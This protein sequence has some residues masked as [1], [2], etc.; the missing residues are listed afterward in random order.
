MTVY[1]HDGEFPPDDR[2]EWSDL[3]PLLGPTA[4]AIARYDG[5]LGLI[6][7]PLSLLTP[8]KVQEA[9]FSSRIEGTQTTVIEVLRSESGGGRVPMSAERQL[10]IQEVLNYINAMNKAE[11]LLEKYPLSQRVI[12]ES[13]IILMQGLRGHGKSPGQ[14][15]RIQNW[16]GPSNCKI[17]EAKFVPVDA[18]KLDD[19]MSKWEKYIHQDHPDQLVQLAI[20]H[21]EFES[22]H[23]FLDGNGRLGRMLIPLFLWQQN[24]LQ[25]PIFNISSYF[26]ADRDSYY[27]GLLS[28]SKDKNWTRWIKYFL[29]ALGKQAE[30]NYQKSYKILELYE[31][32][33]EEV[34]KN[35]RSQYAIL[36]LD[37]I[38]NNPVFR[39]SRFKNNQG[40]P[41]ASANRVL[42]AFKNLDILTEYEKKRGNISAVY[43]FPKLIEI[44][45]S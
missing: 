26:E 32:T 44:I 40:I 20:L 45:D 24:L 22:L 14:Y 41:R 42:S 36:A 5:I 18:Q 12:K 4:T 27:D 3:I 10:D 43:A 1:Y 7:N 29:E 17:D 35:V 13:H 15:R 28:V 30:Y 31:N 9:V 6:P 33:K 39:T 23:P 34:A 8:S 2:L 25:K 37:W 21:A 38:F 19:A 11:K 16:I